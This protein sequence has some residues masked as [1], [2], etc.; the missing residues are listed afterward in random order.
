[1]PDIMQ[2][3]SHLT[4]SE[5]ALGLMQVSFIVEETGKNG[6]TM[7]IESTIPVTDSLAELQAHAL[8]RAAKLCASLADDLQKG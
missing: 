8:N 3:I 5:P 1:M 7:K 2:R 6:V 4:I